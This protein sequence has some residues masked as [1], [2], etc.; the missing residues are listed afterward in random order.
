MTQQHSVFYFISSLFFV[1]TTNIFGQNILTTEDSLLFIQCAEAP[2]AEPHYTFSYT[3]NMLDLEYEFTEKE[4]KKTSKLLEELDETPDDVQLA[5]EIAYNYKTSNDLSNYRT[6]LEYAYKQCFKKYETHPDSFEIVSD[7]ISLLQE[8]KNVQGVLSILNQYVMTKPKD[9]RGLAQFALHLSIQGEIQ[10]ARHFIEQAYLIDPQHPE[11][12]LSAMMCEFT[13]I[14]IQISNAMASPEK[15]TSKIIKSILINDEF[16][17]KSISNN[18]PPA[19]QMGLDAAQVFGVFYRTILGIMDKEISK[20][21]IHIS[22]SSADEALLRAIEKRAKKQLKAKVKNNKFAHQTLFIIEILRGKTKHALDIFNNSGKVL[23]KDADLLRLLS[24]SYFLQLDYDNA[25]LYLEKVLAIAPNAVDS[26]A[27]GRFYN[28]QNQ[29][30]KAYQVFDQT[31]KLNPL[32]RKAACAKAAIHLKQGDFDKA[33]DL[34]D[35][36]PSY[37]K[38]DINAFHINYFTAL[39][40]LAKG[41]KNDAFKRLKAIHAQSDYKEDAEKLLAHFFKSEEE[42]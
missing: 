31:E 38:D 18:G 5:M 37:L 7:L 9:V 13:N 6:Y 11:I 15:E 8:G 1:L 23:D 28:N 16:F 39:V 29:L 40:T 42:E 30:E 41:N 2:M 34:I 4:K 12:Y 10:K 3:G 14:L 22:P 36:Y 24:F 21:V 17:K 33:F 26:Y 25:I 35:A 32:D 19:A 27:L 20:E